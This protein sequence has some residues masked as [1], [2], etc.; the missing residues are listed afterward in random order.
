M[1]IAE[2]REFGE[3]IGNDREKMKYLCRN[4]LRYLCRDVLGY[5]DWDVFHDD[6][7]EFL[8]TNKDAKRKL[9]LVPRGHLKSSI[10]TI[11]LSIQ[12]VLNDVNK[13][14]LIANAV[15]G[16]SKD[17][18]QVISD[19]LTKYSELPV[20]FGSF[21]PTTRGMKGWNKEAL[22]ISQ[23]TVATKEATFT[24][25]GV[26]KA[27]TGA[28]YDKIVMDDLVDR[29]NIGTKEQ[30][31]KVRNFYNDS[32]SLLE[33]DGEIIVI[34][35]TWHEDDLYNNLKKNKEFK[36]YKRTALEPPN[37]IEG[38]PI[39]PKKFSKQTLERLREE[40]RI[41]NNLGQ[42]YAQYFLD[43]YPDENAEFNKIW[44]KYYYDIPKEPMY[45]SVCLDPSLGKATSDNAAL[46]ATG[47]TSKG[48][49]YILQARNFK[50]HIDLIGL[51]VV[52]TLAFLKNQG[53]RASIVG[54]EGFA[55]QQALL[56]PIKDAMKSAGFGDIPIEV[57]PR[58]TEETKDSRIMALIP[59]FAQGLIFMKEEM[60]DLKDE[61]LRFKK[62]VKRRKDD[63]L[64]SL[65]WQIG[66]WRRKPEDQHPVSCPEGSYGAILKE[67]KESSL[68]APKTIRQEFLLN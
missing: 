28:H 55:F 37:F 16:R 27:Q 38:V 66:Y 25:T 31:D 52:K 49:V 50:C 29:E 60:V 57:L 26:E 8:E 33:P 44:N 12:D 56:T 15:W 54:I 41:G 1:N 51:E 42:F 53:L 19:N 5:K 61:M 59:Y 62:N 14:I 67:M 68:N 3:S 18:L 13:R 65:A 21:K 30:R 23:R 46:S 58:S 4:D 20:I 9:I 32:L 64:D 22:S 11:G 43:P 45:I 63:I 48:K 47:V 2:R 10:V 35:T 39:F 40:A 7:Y 34:G 24:S 36:V 6:L 17:F